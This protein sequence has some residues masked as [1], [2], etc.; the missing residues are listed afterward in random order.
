MKRVFFLVLLLIP[1]LTRA[2]VLLSNP[3]N[4]R[5]VVVYA[6]DND[7]S[8][9]YYVPGE[10]KIKTIDHTPEFFFHRYR[11]MGTRATGDSR[12]FK[13]RGIISFTVELGRLNHTTIDRIKRALVPQHQYSSIKLEPMPLEKIQAELVYTTIGKEKTGKLPGGHWVNAEKKPDSTGPGNDEESVWESKRFTI[14]T[15]IVTTNLLWEC[16]H[17]EGVIL[18]LNYSLVA[19]GL[20]D[21]NELP[22]EIE[23][24][25]EEI[26]KTQGKPTKKT[27]THDTDTQRKLEVVHQVILSSS[28]VIAVS[29]NEHPDRFKSIDVGSQMAAGYTFLDVYCYDFQE[30][31]GQNQIFRKEVEIR[32]NSISG[33][34]P[35]E[36]AI[37]SS[38]NPEIYKQSIHFPFAMDLDKGYDYRVKRI[39]KKGVVHRGKWKQQEDWTGIL[40][41]TDY[42]PENK[43]EKKDKKRN[44]Y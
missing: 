1:Q 38:A 8:T 18:S 24:L 15:N 44:L 40:D 12:D 9:Y 20:S 3:K 35:L 32:G 37:F 11:Y 6:D 14:G 26:E 33:S 21:Y 31:T 22:Q 41:V 28:L 39:D 43:K 4:I 30:S 23:Q 29:P 19:R 17:K 10:L 2:D 7:R 36:K 27:T 34:R 13:G 5:G 42:Q 25:K 16:Y